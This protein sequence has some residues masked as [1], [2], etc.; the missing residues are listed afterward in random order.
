MAR[1]FPTLSRCNYRLVTV[2]QEPTPEMMVSLRMFGTVSTLTS[3]FEHIRLHSNSSGVRT[4][5]TNFRP[6]TKVCVQISDTMVA[7]AGIDF[8]AS[9][10]RIEF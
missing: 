3:C 9:L 6:L 4:M 8:E 5:C 2:S 7:V 10:R 1:Q